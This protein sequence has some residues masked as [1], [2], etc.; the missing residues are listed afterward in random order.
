[1]EK[2]GLP[3]PQFPV[4]QHDIPRHNACCEVASITGH[5]DR[6]RELSTGKQ[7]EM[8]PLKETNAAPTSR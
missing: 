4:M 3:E 6:N 2:A 8:I 7:W 1:M 5:Y